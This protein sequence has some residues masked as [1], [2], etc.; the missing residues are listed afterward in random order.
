MSRSFRPSARAKALYVIVALVG[1][2]TLAIAV[3]ALVER[4]TFAPATGAP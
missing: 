3:Y 4:G 1:V 2:L